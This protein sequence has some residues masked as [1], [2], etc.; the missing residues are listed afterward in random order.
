MTAY[1]FKIHRRQW[2]FSFCPRREFTCCGGGLYVEE[3]GGL[4]YMRYLVS[5]GS[6]SVEAEC[7]IKTL[8]CSCSYKM[9]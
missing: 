8:T 9:L 2:D 6:V 4:E 3:C 7:L 1:G 5:K